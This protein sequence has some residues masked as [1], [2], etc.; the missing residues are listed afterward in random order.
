MMPG[1]VLNDTFYAVLSFR[2]VFMDKD[3][4]IANR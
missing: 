4:Q 3:W 1:F 2:I